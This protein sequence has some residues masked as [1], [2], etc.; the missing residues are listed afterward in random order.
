MLPDF[1]LIALLNESVLISQGMQTVVEANDDV[2]KIRSTEARRSRSDFAAVISIGKTPLS[3][4]EQSCSLVDG[5]LGKALC[6]KVAG[7]IDKS[8]FPERRS[9]PSPKNRVHSPLPS[10]NSEVRSPDRPETNFIAR[11]IQRRG[12]FVAGIVT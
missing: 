3:G 11:G 6:T 8:Q 2:F 10:Q 9:L 12:T 5:Q 4:S 1:V 7:K